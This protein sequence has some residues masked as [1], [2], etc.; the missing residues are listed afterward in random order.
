MR[1][2]LPLPAFT[3]HPLFLVALAAL[4]VYL[5]AGHILALFG[6]QLTWT[7]AWKGIGAALGAY[8]FA[9]LALGA[10][11]TPDGTA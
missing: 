5:G 3:G 2:R 10:R 9:A 1:L 6:G 7:D 11:G 8:Y 4:H